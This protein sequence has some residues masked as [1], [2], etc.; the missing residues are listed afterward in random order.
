MVTLNVTNQIQIL[1]SGTGEIFRT[2][3]MSNLL[4]HKQPVFETSAKCTLIAEEYYPEK[5]HT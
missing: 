5:G 4:I 3:N 1:N 2:R